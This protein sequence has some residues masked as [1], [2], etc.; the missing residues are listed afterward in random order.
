MHRKQLLQLEQFKINENFI[1]TGNQKI[2][3]KS[4]IISLQNY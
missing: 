1:Q 3:T 2:S 4:I